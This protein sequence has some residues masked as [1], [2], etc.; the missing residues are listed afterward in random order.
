MNIKKDILKCTNC[1]NVVEILRKGD[2]E[3][4]CCG[5]P[6]VKEESKNNDNGVEKHLPVIKE[7]ETYFEIAVGEVEHP[8]TSEHHIEWV[9]VNTDKES[10]KKF[11]NVNEKPVFNIPKNHKVKNVRAYCNIHGLWRRMNID[12]INREDLILL[13]LKN[14]IDSM[15]VYINLSQRVKNYFLKDRLNFLAGEEEKHKKY[16]EEFYKK[17]YLKEI[18]I[19]VEDVMPL[20]KVDISDPQKPISDILYEAMQS[21]IAAHEFYLDLS[22]V[23][24]DDQ[25]TSNMLKFFSSMEMIHYSILQIERENA[26]KFEDYG[27]EIP[28]IHVGP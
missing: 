15:N 5:K 18:V 25:K 3:L 8:M 28:M 13:A 22:R 2:G 16:F 21:E 19:P 6:M 17:T 26:L 27:N 14:E 23:F 4:F 20:P 9:E 7:K 11:F 12:E 1:K 24:K 10:I